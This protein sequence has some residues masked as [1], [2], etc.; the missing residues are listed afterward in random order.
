MAINFDNLPTEKPENEF[1][2][3]EEGFHIATIE[4]TEMKT[5]QAGNQYLE[6][7]LKLDDGSV[8]YDKIMESDKPALLYKIQRFIQALRM[9]LT[10]T[11]ELS[12]LGTVIKGKKLVADIIH[13]TSTYKEKEYTKA[14]VDIFGNDIYYHVDEYAA[15][16]GNDAPT[17]EDSET[18]NGSY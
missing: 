14:E 4:S 3:P 13:K 10:G 12:D 9:P 7:K 6:M 5:S 15:L 18:T 16:T 2:L 1:S 17:V 8:V 11:I